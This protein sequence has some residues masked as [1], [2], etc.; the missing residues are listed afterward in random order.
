MTIGG[1]KNGNKRHAYRKL[2]PANFALQTALR[3]QN[4]ALAAFC[5]G[6]KNEQS[7][8]RE[9]ATHMDNTTPV[10]HSERVRDRAVAAVHNETTR[11]SR[12]LMSGVSPNKRQKMLSI[13]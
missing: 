10:C 11:T 7:V 3:S 9:N 13:F 5:I 1:G 2:C 4:D 6:R 8:V 12:T